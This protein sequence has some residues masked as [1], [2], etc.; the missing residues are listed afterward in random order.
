M[1]EGVGERAR[2]IGSRPIA[3]HWPF[4]GSDYRRLFVGED[5]LPHAYLTDAIKTRTLLRIAELVG[6][7]QARADALIAEHEDA[8]IAVATAVYEHRRLTDDRLDAVL[9]AAGFTL[10]RTTA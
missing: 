10:P 4:I 3:S 2:A 6:E 5:G 8:L 1:L 7:A 9:V